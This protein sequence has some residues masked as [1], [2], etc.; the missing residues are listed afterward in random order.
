MKIKGVT[1]RGKNTY[2]FTL[3]LGFDGNGNNIRKTRTFKVPEGTSD[4]K[5][6]KLVMAAYSDFQREYKYSQDLEEHMRFTSLWKY[7]SEIS[8]PTN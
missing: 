5:A 6:E 3:S 7:T 4:T 8:P 1:K 2:R